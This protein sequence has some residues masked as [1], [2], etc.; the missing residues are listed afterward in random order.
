MNLLYP[1]LLS[2]AS[3]NSTVPVRK[4]RQV[5]FI[6]VHPQQPPPHHPHPTLQPILEPPVNYP[7]TS[8]LI[9][10]PRSDTPKLLALHHPQS[11]TLG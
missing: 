3:T 10:E 6:S 7:D 9:D 5:G 4:G 11:Y 2:R 1:F 8:L